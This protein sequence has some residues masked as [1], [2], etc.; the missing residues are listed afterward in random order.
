[1]TLWVFHI[2]WMSISRYFM[3][4]LSTVSLWLAI[5]IC[6]FEIGLGIALLLGSKMIFTAWSLCS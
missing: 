5:A 4:W 6:A 3:P 1:M 2:N